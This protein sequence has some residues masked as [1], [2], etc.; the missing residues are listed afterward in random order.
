MVPSGLGLFQANGDV[1]VEGVLNGILFVACFTNYFK[2]QALVEKLAKSFDSLCSL[3]LPGHRSS[4]VVIC[5][6][7]SWSFF[8]FVVRLFFG[9]PKVC[10]L[11]LHLHAKSL[12][13]QMQ[14]ANFR[15]AKK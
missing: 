4:C 7:V 5:A 10:G 11:H 9:A 12:Q 13:M 1:L 15:R 3:R 8:M 2:S 6:K 14:N